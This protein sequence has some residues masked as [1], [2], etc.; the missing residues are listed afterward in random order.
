MDNINSAIESATKKV[1]KALIGNDQL[2]AE[3]YSRVVVNLTQAL[4]NLVG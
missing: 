1:Q 2:A 3:V 4:A